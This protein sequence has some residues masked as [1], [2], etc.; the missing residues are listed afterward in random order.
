MPALCDLRR[1]FSR[2]NFCFVVGHRRLGLIIFIKIMH[3]VWHLI[4][5]MTVKAVAG[6]IEWMLKTGVIIPK[7]GDW[8]IDI[9]SDG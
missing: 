5:V 6:S 9:N 7:S 3:T 4:Y 2:S 1:M 8:I